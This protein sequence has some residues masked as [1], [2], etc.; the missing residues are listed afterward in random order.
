MTEIF[1]II[2]I[3]SSTASVAQQSGTVQD[4][5]GPGVPQGC[6]QFVVDA[7]QRPLRDLR[8]SVTDRCNLGCTY[9]MPRE[10]F[11]KEHAFLQRTDLLSFEEIERLAKL[12]IQLGVQKIRLTG[13]EPL[14][15][16]GGEHLIE[17][18]RKSTRLKS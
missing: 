14:L 7:L 9:C 16:P 2:P 8:I 10:A 4:Y 11:D 5:I 15:R 18:D 3:P 1:R 6:G 12:F 17:S 13:G